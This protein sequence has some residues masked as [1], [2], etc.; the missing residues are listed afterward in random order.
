MSGRAGR[1]N[2]IGIGEAAGWLIVSTAYG[3]RVRGS[4]FRKCTAAGRG[5]HHAY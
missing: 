3:F 2:W 5:S 4:G 1:G